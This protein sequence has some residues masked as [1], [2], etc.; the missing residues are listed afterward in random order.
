MLAMFTACSEHPGG[1][2]AAQQARNLAWQLQEA[3]LRARFLIH[4][5]DSNFPAACCEGFVSCVEHRI[6]PG[7]CF[8]V[9]AS[10]E[11][12]GRHGPVRDR[13]ALYQRQ[14]RE[15][16]TQTTYEAQAAGELAPDSDPEQLAFELS[17]IL[18]GTNI[19]AVLHADDTVIDCARQ[20]IRTRVCT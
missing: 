9:T 7:G 13:V 14:W 15:L 16:M 3:E 19:I 4:D 6:F 20:A 11:I 12:G 10:A 1:A 17:A 2:W 18:A 5:R 8:F